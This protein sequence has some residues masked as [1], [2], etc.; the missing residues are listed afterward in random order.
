MDE[1]SLVERSRARRRV[2]YQYA[3]AVQVTE[4]LSVSTGEC[5]HAC[6]H[7][8]LPASDL[9]ATAMSGAL[10]CGVQRVTREAS[11]GCSLGATVLHDVDCDDYSDIAPR[12][13][14]CGT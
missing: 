6:Y 4:P 8:T 13:S 10:R 2:S 3:C 14:W 5:R 9:A 11:V 7:G 12:T 1:A